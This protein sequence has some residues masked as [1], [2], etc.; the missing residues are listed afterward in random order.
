MSMVWTEADSSI[1]RGFVEH[2]SNTD[3][4]EVRNS[5][6]VELLGTP[7]GS[8]LAHLSNDGTIKTREQMH[9]ENNQRIAVERRLATEEG[10][11]PELGQTPVRVQAHARMLA[12]ISRLRDDRTV[13]VMAKEV[14]KS[15]AE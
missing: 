2:P 11:F 9:A 10:Q 12:Q 5:L 6:T 13:S 4:T 1:G 8:Y 15:N 14:E 3:R 7:N